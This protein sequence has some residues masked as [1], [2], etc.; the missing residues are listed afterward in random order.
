[1]KCHAAH[2]PLGY[3]YRA[4]ARQQNQLPEESPLRLSYQ[5]A[6][7]TPMVTLLLPSRRFAILP[8]RLAS[9]DA[10][11]VLRMYVTSYHA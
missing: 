1:M 5:L 9:G 10:S 11:Y 6:Q 2:Q 4:R 3:R 7:H 8:R